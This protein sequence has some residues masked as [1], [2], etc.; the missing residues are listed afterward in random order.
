MV[1]GVREPRG[2]R[3]A[4]GILGLSGYPSYDDIRTAYCTLAVATHPDRC[5][6]AN[7]KERFQTLHA[8]YEAALEH[9]ARTAGPHGKN[10]GSGGRRGPFDWRL[11]DDSPRTP[12]HRPAAAPT[13]PTAR[14]A[15]RRFT[16]PRPAT[17]TNNTTAAKTTGSNAT[18]TTAAAEQEERRQ[19]AIEQRRRRQ[20]SLAQKQ[21]CRILVSEAAHRRAIAKNERGDLRLIMMMFSEG[22]IRHA[23]EMLERLTRDKINTQRMNVVA[24]KKCSCTTKKKDLRSVCVMGEKLGVGER[25]NTKGIVRI[26]IC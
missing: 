4:W 19:R 17:K 22:R 6:D 10:N 26:Y 23:V 13:T 2:I 11:W 3:R 16:K 25:R 15:R 20:P 21:Q 12:T 5:P 18:N 14:A 24:E 8:A 1:L 7:A 9:H